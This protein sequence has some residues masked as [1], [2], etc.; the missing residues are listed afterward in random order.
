MKKLSLSPKIDLYRHLAFAAVGGFF[1]GYA[2]LSHAGIMGSA[3]TVNLLELVMDIL[4][5]DGGGVVIHLGALALYVLGTM[6]TVILPR[7]W[8][9]DMHRLSPL[10]TAVCAVIVAFIPR[11]VNSVLALYPVFFAMS[12]QWSSF[13]GANGFYSSTIFSTNNT[14]QASLSLAE[15]LCDGDRTHLRK[16]VFYALTLLCFHI[17]AAVSYFGVKWWDLK[18]SLLVLP[19][20]AWSYALAVCERQ[21]ESAQAS[22]HTNA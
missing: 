21:H 20:V 13:T 7:K 1:G 15:F 2:I 18:G 4:R 8:G 14:K 16:T 17:G 9:V 6:L 22:A 19:L 10:L 12:V 5:L 3:Q 11:H